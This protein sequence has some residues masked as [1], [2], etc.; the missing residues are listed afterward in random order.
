MEKISSI[1]PP[2]FF[3]FVVGRL[4][5]SFVTLV[6]FQLVLFFLI[7]GVSAT[8]AYDNALASAVANREDL[9]GFTPSES[10]DEGQVDDSTFSSGDEP[11][12]DLG[13]ALDTGDLDIF[14]GIA[15][16]IEMPPGSEAPQTKEVIQEQ[17]EIPEVPVEE[18]AVPIP[19]EPPPTNPWWGEFVGWMTAFY[20]GELGDSWSLGSEP[21]AQILKMKLPR[22]LIL[23]I[24]GTMFGFLLGLWAGKLVAWKPRG[25]LEFTATLGGTVFYT[26]FPPWLALV[27]FYFN[28]FELNW[29]PPESL[30]DP[31]K[32]WQVDFPVNEVVIHL[33]ITI[34]FAIAFYLFIARLTRDFAHKKSILWRSLGGL[35][36][37]VAGSI[38][39]VI[40]GRIHLV[41][42]ILYH[43][44]LPILALVLL[45]FAETMLIMK[46]SMTEMVGAEH[47]AT[48]KAKGLPEARVRDRHA[49]RIAI[50][51]VLTRF[52]VHVPFIFIGSI[53][54]EEQF[55]LT[56]M[57]EELFRAASESDLPVLLGVLSVVGIGILLAHTI[58]DIITVWLDPRLRKYDQ[59]RHLLRN[60]D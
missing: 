35:G 28:V 18:S 5:R 53:I 1:I 40:I 38:T 31:I 7:K 47:V 9:S 51:P 19:D 46:T 48:A 34:L 60:I 13:L 8:V 44:I 2:G 41:L 6:L 45:S 55:H 43:L 21:V 50:L 58:L 36:I 4:L 15:I 17:D 42:D 27:I 56:G 10:A 39:W 37:I 12:D 25:W 11:S 20:R 52:I 33:L 32:W 30:I 57:G 49:S 59:V 24:P 26:A 54:I 23:F 3:R 14:D 29:F 22:T 16:D